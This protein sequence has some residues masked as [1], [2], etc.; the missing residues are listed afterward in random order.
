M[1]YI[2]WYWSTLY[3]ALEW[4]YEFFMILWVSGDFFSKQLYLSGP[5]NGD[6]VF[7]M[8][9]ELN[10]QIYLDKLQAALMLNVSLVTM[11]WH[12]MTCCKARNRVFSRYRHSVDILSCIHHK[13][14]FNLGWW[15][16]LLTTLQHKEP[17]ACYKMLYRA[18]KTL[19]LIS[20]SS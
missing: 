3:F 15:G 12:D 13:W 1:N 20:T 5:C 10:F 6:T 9:L 2:P 14:S 17:L 8:R 16:G 11:A 18:D 4:D 7:S 19:F